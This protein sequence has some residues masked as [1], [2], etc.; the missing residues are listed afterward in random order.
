M[1]RGALAFVALG[2]AVAGAADVH[3]QSGEP[4]ALADNVLIQADALAYDETTNEVVA[5][6]SVELI[7]GDRILR[8]QEVR[9]NQTTGVAIASG[10][11]VL[12]EPTGDVLFADFVEL[13]EELTR[14]FVKRVG[15]LL[16]DDSRFAAADGARVDGNRTEMRRAVY[17]PCDVCEEDVEADPIWQLKARRIIHDEAAQDVIYY[18]AFLEIFGV[19]VLYSPFF[20]HPDPTVE[21]RS[22]FLAPSF[23][24]DSRD[25]FVA[26]IPYYYTVSPDFDMTASPI[27]LTEQGAILKGEIRKR[28]R[29]GELTVAGS[30]GWLDYEK[31]DGEEERR[32]RGLIDAQAVFHIDENWRAT[33][34]ARRASDTTYQRRFDLGNEDRL[35]SFAEAERFSEQSYLRFGARSFQGLRDD[36]SDGQAPTILPD[37]EAAQIYDLGAAPGALTLS[38]RGFGLSRDSGPDSARASLAAE[39]RAPFLLPLGQQATVSASLRADGFLVGNYQP[40]GEDDIGTDGRIYPSAALDWRWPFARFGE[41]TATYLEPMATVVIAPYG[42]QEDRVPNEDSQGLALDTSLLFEHQRYAGIDRVESGLRAAYGLRAGYVGEFG[43]AEAMVGQAYR[44]DRDAS[45]E[46]GSGLENTLSDVVGSVRLAPSRYVSGEYAFRLND[47][48]LAMLEQ[49]A[50]LSV[51]APEFRLT[52]SYS[53]VDGDSEVAGYGDREQFSLGFSSQ[54]HEYWKLSADWLRDMEDGINLNYSVG[55]SYFD[56]CFEALVG[57]RR[58]NYRDREIEPT[59]SVFFRVTFKHLGEFGSDF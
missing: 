22:G 34:A 19:P 7:E 14:G 55:L 8:A 32:L 31:A 12:V 25:G 43:S 9:Y 39:W 56:E 2:A 42:G 26:E 17:T 48:N 47:G 51:G 52:G 53:F 6:G 33:L 54:F 4:A 24:F 23:K 15:V 57:F 5:T 46:A 49:N 36:E 29:F 28:W 3:A 16:S 11:V 27:F 21:R 59:S 30:G 44:W 10:E 38:A 35:E 20:T 41:T 45:Y 50:T 18:H 1:R 40:R 58:Q 13:E 37:F